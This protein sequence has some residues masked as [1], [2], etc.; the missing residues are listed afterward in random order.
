MNHTGALPKNIT[1]EMKVQHSRSTYH[2]DDLQAP[3]SI[4]FTLPGRSLR[5]GDNT[6]EAAI[7]YTD[8]L[9]SMATEKVQTNV[10]LDN[11]G[12]ADRIIFGLED[13]AYL[14]I[15]LFR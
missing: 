3:A 5:P 6:I 14:V 2:L 9:G 10:V 13:A 8:E 12:A 4:A 7:S 11:V 1:I 15:D